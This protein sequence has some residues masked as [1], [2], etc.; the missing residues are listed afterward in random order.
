[1]AA[2]FQPA[3]RGMIVRSSFAVNNLGLVHIQRRVDAQAVTGH[4]DPVA[5]AQSGS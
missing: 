2:S 4:V 5:A 3:S 1:L